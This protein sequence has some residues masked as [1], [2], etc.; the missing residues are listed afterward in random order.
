VTA[1]SDPE[2]DTGHYAGPTDWRQAGIDRSTPES[3]RDTTDHGRCA[4][5][6]RSHQSFHMND[7]GWSDYAY[8]GAFCP[9][10]VGFIGRG[11][12]VRTAAQG[13]TDGNNR[14][15]ALQYMGAGDADPLTV[16]AQ[17]AAIDMTTW[18]GYPL[19]RGHKDWKST[20]CPGPHVYA[21]RLAGFPHPPIG[22]DDMPLNAADKQWIYDAIVDVVRK[23]GISNNAHKAADQSF[24]AVQLLEGI[25]LPDG[26]TVEDIANGVWDH[27]LVKNLA[28]GESMP[29]KSFIRWINANVD[30]IKAA[31]GSS[32]PGA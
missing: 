27:L 23:E 24:K 30:V 20:S 6:M 9:H 12:G 13:T 21:W 2:M 31:V 17:R 15:F 22:D 16:E 26:I 19:R 8:S 7:R 25:D 4:A 18:L 10:G 29:A 32:Q 14:S 28:T 3:F 11:R 1:I 5:I